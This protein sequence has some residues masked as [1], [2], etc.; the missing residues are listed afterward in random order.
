MN[1]RR[2][3]SRIPVCLTVYQQV[4]VMSTVA[5]AIR[6]PQSVASLINASVQRKKNGLISNKAADNSAQTERL[7]TQIDQFKLTKKE[8]S[9]ALFDECMSLYKRHKTEANLIN[10][11]LASELVKPIEKYLQLEILNEVKEGYYT[12]QK[13]KN[14]SCLI[15]LTQQHPQHP[16]SILVNKRYESRLGEYA[17]FQRLI[18]RDARPFELCEIQDKRQILLNT[19]Y[20]I[21]LYT[22]IAPQHRGALVTMAKQISNTNGG[23]FFFS[24]KGNR[25]NDWQF[26]FRVLFHFDDHELLNACIDRVGLNIRTLFWVL[27]ALEHNPTLIDKMTSE[28]KKNVRLFCNRYKKELIP[29]SP[30]AFPKY[31]RFYNTLVSLNWILHVKSEMNVNR[32]KWLTI[33]GRPISPKSPLLFP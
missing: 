31:I 23:L 12:L 10:L 2:L 29:E 1:T 32:M 8:A 4:R 11:V 28:Q 16:V 7:G 19:F 33:G 13:M 6:E 22:P 24:T 18:S 21:P 5:S 27:S 20:K 26:V 30:N 15:K 17:W 9:I 14:L 3:L 25:K